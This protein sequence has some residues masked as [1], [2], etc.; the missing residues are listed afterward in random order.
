[1]AASGA[2]AVTLTSTGAGSLSYAVGNDYDSATPRTLGSG[3]APVSQW[4]NTNTGDTFWVQGTS[5]PSAASGQPVTLNDTAPTADQ[6][7]FAAVG[8]LAGLPAPPPPPPPTPPPGSPNQP[9]PRAAPPP[10]TPPPG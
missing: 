2:S 4:V 7:N 10:P 3:Q 6:W 5:S 1:A 8:G 9:P